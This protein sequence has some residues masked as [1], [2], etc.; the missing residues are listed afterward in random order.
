MYDCKYSGTRCTHQYLGIGFQVVVEH[1][2]TDGEIPCVE[3]VGPVP[4]LGAELPPLN[5]HRMEVDE[6]EEDA[7]ELT[8]SRTHLKCVLSVCVCVCVCMCVCVC[9][10]VWCTCVCI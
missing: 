1:I 4:A 3:R 5:E 2:D 9:V 6:R 8:L 7:L 10:C